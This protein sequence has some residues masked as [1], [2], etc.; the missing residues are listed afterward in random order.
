MTDNDAAFEEAKR[1]ARELASMF[2]AEQAVTEAELA[3]HSIHPVTIAHGTPETPEETELIYEALP[4]LARECG[5]LSGTRGGNEYTTWLFCGPGAA[6]N[7]AAFIA[8]VTS[9][10][11]RWWRVTATAHPVWP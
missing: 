5:P 3:A 11:P 4:A 2:A 10:A 8:V 9:I 7:G 1:R 6:E